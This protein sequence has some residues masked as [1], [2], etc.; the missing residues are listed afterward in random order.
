M[1]R[2]ALTCMARDPLNQ[3]RVAAPC[4]ASW[5]SMKGDERVRSCSQCKLN[6]YNL[7][8]MHPKEARALVESHE[9]RLCVRFYQRKD[10]TIITRNCPAGLAAMRKRLAYAL[11]IVGAIAF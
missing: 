5:N 3:V 1:S 10:G 4:S 8:E 9:G 2:R 6:V 11:S 7:S